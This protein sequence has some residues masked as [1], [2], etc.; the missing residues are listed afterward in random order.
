M[1]VDRKRVLLVF[2]EKKEVVQL[3]DRFVPVQNSK[4]RNWQDMTHV[5]TTTIYQQLPLLTEYLR[6]LTVK[7]HIRSHQGCSTETRA[8]VKST[9]GATSF[10]GRPL[11]EAVGPPWVPARSRS[12]SPLKQKLA[13]VEVRSR[14]CPPKPTSDGTAVAYRRGLRHRP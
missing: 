2:C 8:V 6:E 12:W 5:T 1:T 10:Y 11:G 3:S 13:T 9:P 7:R 14:R 4:R